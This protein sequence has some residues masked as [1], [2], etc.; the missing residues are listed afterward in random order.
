MEEV[1]ISLIVEMQNSILKTEGIT[2]YCEDAVYRSMQSKPVKIITGF[3]RSG[4]S[5]LVKQIARRLVEESA[6]RSEN[7]L[8]LNFEHYRLSEI[9]SPEKLDGVF[10]VFRKSIAKEP[11]K[12]LLIFDEIQKVENWDR[13][14]RTVYEMNG[15]NVEIILTGSNSELLSGELGSNLAGRFIEFRLLPF[16]FREFLDYSGIS[17]KKKIDLVRNKDAV[18]KLFSQYRVTGGLPE[19]FSIADESARYS[20]LQGIISKVIIDDVVQRFGI[21]NPDIV[22]KILY[23][24]NLNAGNVISL[25]RLGNFIARTGSGMSANS[26]IQYVNFI[27]R[28][29]AVFEVRKFDWKQGRVFET[30][31]KYYSIDTGITNSFDHT[32][33]N[34]AKMLENIVFLELLRRKDSIYFAS[35][36]SVKEI[37]F[38]ARSR[39]EDT[40]IKYQVTEVLT[41]ENRKR[42][43]SAFLTDDEYLSC[44]ENILLTAFGENEQIKYLSTAINKIN[45]IEWLCAVE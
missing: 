6:Y 39:N 18:A 26:V 25:S 16:S 34:N 5:F 29:F 30:V 1:L 9:N 8:Y 36:K 11:E 14:I 27:I 13:F 32:V 7:I 10:T 22:E 31:K 3:R 37:D 23:F 43:L 17:I 2:R 15:D 44:G 19:T 24:L 35:T 28:S 33:R 21:K 20:Y 45:L 41:D 12:L 4:K 38:I 42:E 40:F